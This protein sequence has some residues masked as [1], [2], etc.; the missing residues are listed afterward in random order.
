MS[1]SMYGFDTVKAR[2]REA[3]ERHIKDG[4]VEMHQSLMQ[5]IKTSGEGSPVA[6]GALQANMNVS[7]GAPDFSQHASSK[8]YNYPPRKGGPRPR[9]LPPRH[10]SPQSAAQAEVGM[11]RFKLGDTIYIANGSRG[12][13][14]H[15]YAVDIE[16]NATG[17]VETAPSWQAPGGFFVATLTKAVRRYRA[18]VKKVTI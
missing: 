1:A 16:R 15:A 2:F 18:R 14:D 9:P 4:V 5:D 11:S 7:I 10:H 12:E 3:A 13:G 6:S 17:D 8:G